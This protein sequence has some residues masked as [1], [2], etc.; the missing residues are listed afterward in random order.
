MQ[1]AWLLLDYFCGG[2]RRESPGGGLQSA[3]NSHSDININY[4][5]NQYYLPGSQAFPG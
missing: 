1:C 3:T 5:E 2:F 4:Y